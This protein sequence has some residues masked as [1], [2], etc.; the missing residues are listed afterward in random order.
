MVNVRPEP[1]EVHIAPFEGPMDLLLYLVQK[2]ELDPKDISLA[3]IADQY[4]AWLKN[5]AEADLSEAGD[6][7]VMAARLMAMKVREL[8]PKDQQ[9]E[10]ELM[11]FDQD[12]EKLI[13]QMLEYQRYKDVASRLSNMEESHIGTFYRGR[14]E[15][16]RSEEESLADAGIWQLYKAF[17]RSLQVQGREN[18][19]TIELD[20]V[21]IEDRQQHVMNFL[22]R[23][24]RALL[25]DLLGRDTRPLVLV[26]TFMALMEMVKTEDVLLRQSETKGALWIYRRKSNQGF[27]EEMSVDTFI[28]SLDH[29]LQPGVVDAVRK[30]NAELASQTTV[31]LDAVMREVINQVQQGKTIS[32]QDLI[33]MLDGKVALESEEPKVEDAAPDSTAVAVPV[34]SVVAEPTASDA[35]VA[36]N[37]IVDMED[38]NSVDEEQPRDDMTSSSPLSQES[39]DPINE[40][41]NDDIG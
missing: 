37:V 31:T 5:F 15:R 10:M 16:A 25:E 38:P 17:R 36:E 19:H 24:G 13:Q 30:R 26:V 12:R 23:N 32:D 34:E 39:V 9:S 8:L 33:A 21:T 1:Y 18:I 29:E 6:F 2:N 35:V 27:S 7:L 4:L 22:H 41:P 20:D 11:E 3:Q 40:T 14:L 28:P